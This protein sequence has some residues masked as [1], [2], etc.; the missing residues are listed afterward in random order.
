MT[1][2]GARHYAETKSYPLTDSSGAV[3]SA[4]ETI[5]DITDKRKLEEQLRQAQKMEAVGTLAGGVAHD[6]N[7]ILTAIIGYATLSK[8]KMQA[9]DPQRASIDQILSSAE[10]AAHLTQS[11]LAFSRKQIINPKPVNLN[12]IVKG[13]EKLLQRLI[14]EDIELS[15]RL[16]GADLVVMADAGQIEQVLMNLATN[17][18][19]AMPDGGV[20]TL[21]TQGLDLDED[22]MK[23]HGFGNPGRYAVI[24]VSD[25]GCGMDEATREKIFEPFF[26]TKELGRGT[27][28]GLAIVYGIVK[29]HN[30]NIA[31]YSE[32]GK[33]TTFR[34]YLP[35][36]TSSVEEPPALPA[37]PPLG[38]TET[39][40]L[41]E[42]DKDVRSLTMAVLQGFGYHVIEAVDGQDALAKF[43][44][45][46]ADIDL[47]LVDV[48]M[49]KIGGRDVYDA[50]KTIRPGIKV[51]FSSGYPADIIHKK[52][53]VDEGLQFI[54]KPVR[55][56]DLLRKVREVLDEKP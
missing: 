30:G 12:D 17:A 51:L 40:L 27:G 41:A 37:A 8:M 36:I 28:L 10:R 46:M 6:F 25:T 49:P 45:H 44:K 39:I 16:A 42:D 11:L 50:A 33:G 38:G 52:G 54:S 26:T 2:L 13:V 14:G 20:I 56:G 5:T 23:V 3:I 35:L 34:M 53:I 15:T 47:L 19:D 18:R 31:A 4:I 1:D 29:Q 22:F 7:N 55:P 43:R 24:S 21:T 48:V 32:P 9:D